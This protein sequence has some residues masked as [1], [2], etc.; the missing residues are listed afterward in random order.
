M[1]KDIANGLFE[2]YNTNNPFEICD[3]LGITVLKHN[4][5][6]KLYGF[7]QR[8]EDNIEILHINNTLDEYMQKYICA[9]ELAHAILHVNLS[10]AF[11]I[12]NPL[13][14]KGRYEIEADRFAA[15]LLI[16]D[17]DIDL[18]YINGMT[19]EQ[20]AAYY[21]VPKEIIELK[22]ERK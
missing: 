17:N 3:Y 2:Q 5:G 8:T 20:I 1:I 7:F 19:I 18:T 16:N 15:E 22:F 4:M 11:F 14:V 13:M 10:I 21:R 9:H 6:S 12:N